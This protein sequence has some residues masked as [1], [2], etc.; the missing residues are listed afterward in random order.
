MSTNGVSTP[1]SLLPRLLAPVVGAV[2]GLINLAATGATWTI[3]QK[4]PF[5]ENAVWLRPDPRRPWLYAIDRANCEVLF[6][7]LPTA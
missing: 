4:I 5:G 2:L 1:Q 6:I 7:E 3:S